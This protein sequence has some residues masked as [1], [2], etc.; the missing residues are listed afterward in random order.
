MNEKC[1]VLRMRVEEGM[2]SNE[3]IG[4]GLVRASVTK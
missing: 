3:R 1:R 4:I 2:E